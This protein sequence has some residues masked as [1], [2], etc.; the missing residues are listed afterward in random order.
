MRPEGL[1]FGTCT[2]VGI[3]R[4]ALPGVGLC[5]VHLTDHKA[6]SA[7]Y[8]LSSHKSDSVHVLGAS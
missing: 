6:F 1:C 2:K 3:V 5:L 4:A 7:L 8:R